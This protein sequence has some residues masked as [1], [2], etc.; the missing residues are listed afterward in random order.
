MKSESTE[1]ESGDMRE[2]AIGMPESFVP[3]GAVHR[4]QPGIH[5]VPGRAGRL[6]SEG[7]RDLDRTLLVLSHLWPVIGL[8]TA[9]MPF[10]WIGA[11]FVWVLRKDESPLIDDQGRE[12]INTL[13]TSVIVSLSALTIIAI[14]FVL[15][16][17]VV[18]F[19]A[20]IRGAI[21]AGNGEYFRYPMTI[22]F[23]K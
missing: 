18:W 12:I 16:W 3:P 7:E 10:V 6:R 17:F 13:L 21:A 2:P 5:A 22:R 4:G 9:T 1:S 14:P 19:I 15:F 23:L 11:I 20:S 8:L